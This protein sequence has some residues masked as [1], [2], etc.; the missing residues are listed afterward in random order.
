MGTYEITYTG[1]DIETSFWRF[2]L[3]VGKRI[4]TLR[5]FD[6]RAVEGLSARIHFSLYN[7]I[8]C[9]HTYNSKTSRS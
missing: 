5:G 1:T 3:K 8:L 9:P 2:A 6:N 7:L 4:G